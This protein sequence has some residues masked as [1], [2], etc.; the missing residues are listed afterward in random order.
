MEHVGRNQYLSWNKIILLGY[1]PDARKEQT[2]I[3]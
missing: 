2:Q 1:R 3:P